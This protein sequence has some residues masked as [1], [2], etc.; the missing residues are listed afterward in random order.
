MVNAQN[1]PEPDIIRIK[2]ISEYITKSMLDRSYPAVNVMHYFEKYSI[3]KELDPQFMHALAMMEKGGI[4]R[5]DKDDK[6][7]S[8]SAFVLL[9]EDGQVKMH[10][11]IDDDYGSNTFGAMM[12]DPY[13]GELKRQTC[14]KHLENG[15][16]EGCE[17]CEL[18]KNSQICMEHGNVLSDCVECKISSELLKGVTRKDKAQ[19]AITKILKVYKKQYW[20]FEK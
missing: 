7:A 15:Y 14:Y 6:I 8:N 12:N 19:E 10:H 13:E 1:M 16:T 3:N 11:M 2:E 18:E 17:K 9:D 4:I 20:S 5:L